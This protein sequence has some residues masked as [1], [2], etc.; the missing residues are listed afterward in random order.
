MTDQSIPISAID[1]TDRLRPVDEDQATMIAASIEEREAQ[2]PGSGLLQPIRVRWDGVSYVL[3]AGAHRLAAMK[4]LGWTD[5][6]VGQH[7]IISNVSDLQA[8]L[9][10][11]EENVARH[12]LKPLDRAIFLAEHKRIYLELHPETGHGKAKK[13]KKSDDDEEW[14]SSPLFASPRFTA[15]VADRVHLSERTIRD[16]IRL[17][18]ALDEDA[19]ALLRGTPVER[20]QKELF[21]LA[22]LDA[23]EQVQIATAIRDGEARSVAA[24]CLQL[25]LTTREE[26]DP[27]ARTLAKLTAAWV[28]AQPA[29]K[30]KFMAEFAL[31]F[32]PK[33]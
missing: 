25:G 3:V 9:D 33:K 19:I 5:L 32:A 21:T 8:R 23:E 20:N 17:A 24:A 31:Q 6:F 12:E 14:Q 15:E 7:V 2:T 26:Q 11:I 30:K 29:T 4:M 10:E 18:N 1:A 27:E 22:D 13:S 16:A 28:A